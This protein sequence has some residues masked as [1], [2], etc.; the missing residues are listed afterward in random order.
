MVMKSGRF[1][2]ESVDGLLRNRW[3]ESIGIGGRLRPESVDGMKRNMHAEVIY[4]PITNVPKI[5][6]NNTI[7]MKTTSNIPSTILVNITTPIGITIF[8]K[9][10][11]SFLNRIKQYPISLHRN[12]ILFSGDFYGCVPMILITALI[13]RI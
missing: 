8:V 9:K 2:P 13:I 7:T 11:L 6:I 3:T 12:S 1:A 5:D 4:S 10:L